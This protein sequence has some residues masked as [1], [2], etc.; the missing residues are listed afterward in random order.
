MSLNTSSANTIPIFTLW[1]RIG[2]AY[3]TGQEATLS[4]T[5][6]P[7]W[8][9]S[10]GDQGTL[11]TRIEV[12]SIIQNSANMVNLFLNAPGGTTGI[13]W[14][15]YAATGTQSTGLSAT[16]WATADT[17]SISGF[18]LPSGWSIRAGQMTGGT[19]WVIINAE[20]Y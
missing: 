13:L 5:P 7:T 15:Q 1:P 10:A 20:D 17:A 2:T 18:I 3:L 16:A 12:R 6:L 4:G 8:V 9:I 11:I 14:R 19:A